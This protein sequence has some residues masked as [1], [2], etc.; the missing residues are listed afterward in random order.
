M[1]EL[2][3]KERKK[4][5]PHRINNNTDIAGKKTTEPDGIATKTIQNQTCTHK[6]KD[7]KKLKR[8]P[9]NYGTSRSHIYVSLRFPKEKR[10]RGRLKKIF[11]EIMAEIFQ[12]CQK[13]YTHRSKLSKPQAQEHMKETTPKHTIIKL[14]KTSNKEKNLESNQRGKRCIAYKMTNKKIT[15]HF[16]F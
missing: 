11:Q 15:A 6:I 7:F 12:I 4:K 9:M 5:S 8:A 2:L 1:A 16:S 3:K 10:E 14:L 13:L